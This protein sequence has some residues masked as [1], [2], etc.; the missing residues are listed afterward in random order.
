[1]L[2]TAGIA[3]KGSP[4]RLEEKAKNSH[5][6]GLTA[7]FSSFLNVDGGLFTH[8]SKERLNRKGKCNKIS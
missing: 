3:G 2:W 5:G 7:P 4:G 1:M 8:K 6:V